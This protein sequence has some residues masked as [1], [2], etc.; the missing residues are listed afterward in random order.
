[1][2]SF[3]RGWTRGGEGLLADVK[4]FRALDEKKEKAKEQSDD[5]DML[6]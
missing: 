2:D 1:M 3:C 5:G 4:L 6:Q